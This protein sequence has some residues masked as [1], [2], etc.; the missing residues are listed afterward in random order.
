MAAKPDAAWFSRARLLDLE[1]WV[2][3]R[4]PPNEC[5][6]LWEAIIPMLT[7]EP[8]NDLTWF[9]EFHAALHTLNLETAVCETLNS[10]IQRLVMDFRWEQLKQ[11]LARD[12]PEAQ[13]PLSDDAAFQRIGEL[14]DRVGRAIP[15]Q[16]Q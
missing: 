3:A 12:W 1:A 5:S 11:A 10:R 8:Q 13:C 6:R 14:A 4:L 15:S 7:T 2:A 9:K 16:W